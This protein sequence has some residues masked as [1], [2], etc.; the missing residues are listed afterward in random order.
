M[1]DTN[2]KV[3]IPPEVLKGIEAVRISGRTNMLDRNAVAAI[4]LDLGHVD[5]AFWLDD[6][7]NRK[8]YA[9]GIFRGF[10]AC[11]EQSRTEDKTLTP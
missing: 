5:A 3:A 1:S 7:A 4:A 6:K 11:G 10:R 8:A 2:A 9:E